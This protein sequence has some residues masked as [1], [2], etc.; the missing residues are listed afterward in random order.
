MAATPLAHHGQ[1]ASIILGVALCAVAIG[2]YLPAP[3]ARATL[4]LAVV[5]TAVIWVVGQDF[6]AIFTGRGTDPG[7]AP[8]L[9]L[10]AAAYWP[11]G[12]AAPGHTAKGSR[13]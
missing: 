2:V 3:A 6:G 9:M 4:V 5:V 8:L 7:S 10:L 13:W 1:Q 12:A 11:A